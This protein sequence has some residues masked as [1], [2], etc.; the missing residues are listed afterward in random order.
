[1][2]RAIRSVDLACGMYVAL[3]GTGILAFRDRIDGWE[4]YALL[5]MGL[6]VAIASLT[7]IVARRPGIRG[8]SVVRAIYPIAVIAIAW[9][10]LD[11]IVPMLFGNYWAT[12]PIVRADRFLFGISPTV[13]VQQL[14]SPVLDELMSLFYSGYYFFMPLIVFVFLLRGRVEELGRVISIVCFALLSCDLLYLLLPALG[15]RMADATAGAHTR[16]YGGY[17]FAEITR[18]IQSGG[19]IRGGCFPS[20]HVVGAILWPLASARYEPALGRSIAPIAIGVP[21]ATVY[22]GYHHAVDALAGIILGL[23]IYRVSVWLSAL[24]QGSAPSVGP[25]R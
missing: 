1:M 16:E 24:P 4:R 12:D 25:S 3:V 14:Y 5:H 11:R 23:V 22:L 21:P 13:W 7:L 19:G 18:G 17:L 10:E 2:S 6:L 8:L 9:G 15:P 20:S